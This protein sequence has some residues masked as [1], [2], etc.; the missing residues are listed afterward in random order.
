MKRFL[1]TIF[2]LNALYSIYAEDE[3]IYDSDIPAV[4]HLARGKNFILNFFISILTQFLFSKGLVTKSF[5][6]HYKML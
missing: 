1:V 3:I 4:N 2:L 5:G 6:I